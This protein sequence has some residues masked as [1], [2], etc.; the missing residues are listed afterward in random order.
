MGNDGI[1]SVG[2]DL[3]YQIL[4]IGKT[5]CFVYFWPEG[6]TRETLTKTICHNFSHS[7][8]V[9]S[10]CYTGYK[11]LNKITIKFGIELKPTQLSC[12][13][14]LYNSFGHGKKT[15]KEHILASKNM[16]IK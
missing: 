12:K 8:H 4:Q 10:T 2:R 3:E 16:G 5:E 7:S 1:Y 11:R 14:Q 6:L 15:M 9:L 13:S